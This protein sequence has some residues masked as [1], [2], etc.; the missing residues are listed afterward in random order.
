MNLSAW[1]QPCG[2]VACGD[3][4]LGDGLGAC[5]ELRVKV[6]ATE[7]EVRGFGPDGE[8]EDQEEVEL[9]LMRESSRTLSHFVVNKSFVHEIESCELAA[10]NCTR[11]GDPSNDPEALVTPPV[12]I[13]AKLPLDYKPYTKISLNGPHGPVVVMPTPSAKAGQTLIYKLRAPPEFNIQV[14]P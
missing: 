7:M 14:P 9:P 8:E 4:G 12:T 13:T 10:V 3:E 5:S 1:W 6:M 11:A 2:P